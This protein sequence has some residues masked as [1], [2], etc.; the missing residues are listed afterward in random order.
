MLLRLRNLLAGVWLTCLVAVG[1]HA[2]TS[3]VIISSDNS[4]AY[5]E[6]AQAL[7]Q[8]LERSGVSRQS[9][10]QMNASEWRDA[11][12]PAPR[13]YVTLGAEAADLLARSVPS[14]PVLC[15]LLPRSSFEATLLR[16]GRKASSQ[17]SALFLDQ[18]VQRQFQLIRLA[19]PAVRRVGVLWGPE[20]SKESSAWRAQ[21]QAA[22][23]QLVEAEVSQ[24]DR[25]FP[26]LKQ[27]L[28]G[29]DLLLAVPSPQ[30]YNNGTIQN[31]LLASFRA[32][33]PMMAFSPA[34]VRAGALLAV[35]VTPVQVGTQ[36]AQLARAFLEGKA[37]PATGAYSNDFHI[38]VNEHV[39]RS[40]GLT[41]DAQD[42]TWRLRQ[43]EGLP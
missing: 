18:P 13:L 21:A 41:L 35:Y 34:Y 28:D 40:L 1:A 3:V 29:T 9:V 16:N 26:A 14:A 43:R 24:D 19:F 38:S 30:V 23:V 6:T 32:N 4:A 7:I 42:L 2:A 20:A 5:A 39:A 15:A 10:L 36:A 8:E 17:I 25:L 11:R 33:V 31:I 22:A 27:V 37:L 12:P